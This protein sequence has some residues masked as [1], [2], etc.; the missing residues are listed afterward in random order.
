M[1]KNTFEEKKTLNPEMSSIE[2]LKRNLED[3]IRVIEMLRKENGYILKEKE[4][5][6]GENYQ[7]KLCLKKNSEL[8]RKEISKLT[9]EANRETLRLKFISLGLGT[10]SFVLLILYLF[11]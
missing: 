4:C 8:L 5:L 6:M 2:I 1:D 10:I 11:K 7:L 3:A 9:A